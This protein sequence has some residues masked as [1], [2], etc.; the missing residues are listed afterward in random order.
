[1]GSEDTQE[2]QSRR[3]EAGGG[4][5]LA[6]GHQQYEE[7]GGG[8]R[9]GPWQHMSGQQQ[10]QLA[11]LDMLAAAQMQR[12]Q[13]QHQHQRRL[14]AQELQQAQCHPPGMG[15]GGPM[16]GG[17]EQR[18][19]F[20]QPGLGMGPK[21]ARWGCPTP[22]QGL[23]P[24]PGQQ[25]SQGFSSYPAWVASP[26]QQ[27]PGWCEGMG[28]AY[29]CEDEGGGQ[30]G[31]GQSKLRWGEMSGMGSAGEMWPGGERAEAMYGWRS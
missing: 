21:E 4:G 5:G 31:Q 29:G 28:Q 1:M 25:T 9:Q 6:G 26:Q 19:G 20:A 17:P 7:E 24:H 3:E 14:E 10:H 22:Y 23:P 15:M 13:H 8:P 27:W 18:L 30:W 16:V 12:Q 11:K 2:V